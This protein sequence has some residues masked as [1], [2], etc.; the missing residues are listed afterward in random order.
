MEDM[1]EYFSQMDSMVAS[2]PMPV[3]YSGWKVKVLCHD[4]ER[5][6]EVPYH[7]YY[8]K[9]GACGSYNTRV[10]GTTLREGATGLTAPLPPPRAPGPPSGSSGL[11]DGHSA[12]P[13]P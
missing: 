9:C 11:E 2:Q 4:C 10:E 12:P 6:S 3:E 1:T 8:L 7:F 13:G 5:Y